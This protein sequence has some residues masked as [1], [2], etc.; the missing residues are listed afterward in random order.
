MKKISL[1]TGMMLTAFILMAGTALAAAQL[2]LSSNM[3]CDQLTVG[4]TASS[5]LIVGAHTLDVD[6]GGI[7][8]NS[9]GTLT[10]GSGA[11]QCAGNWNNSGTFTAGDGTVNLDGTDAGPQHQGTHGTQIAFQCFDQPTVDKRQV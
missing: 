5:T 11:V 7:N 3:A 2:T 8:I 1:W 4:G 6:T 10:S 9:G